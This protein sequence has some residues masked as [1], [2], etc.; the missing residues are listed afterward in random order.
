MKIQTKL[1]FLFII[2]VLASNIMF[3][4]KKD[5]RQP[6]PLV[7]YKSNVDAPLTAKELAQIK[8]VY[9]DQAE[10]EILNRSQRVKDI[11][12]LLRNR[13]EIKLVPGGDLKP[14][15]LLSEVSLFDAYV[16]TLTRD[17][18]FNPQNFNPLK[19][20][21]NF[22]SRAAALYKVDNTN[23]YIIIKTQYQ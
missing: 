22:Y 2:S 21:L 17:T 19:Y 5:I 18:N 4:Q 6:L 10:K 3:S 8:E 13:I 1:V 14:C 20:N 9:G 23:Y 16:Q 15:P 7:K 11:K 12:H